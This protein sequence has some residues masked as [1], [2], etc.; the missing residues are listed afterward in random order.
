MEKAFSGR[1][2][3]QRSTFGGG[4]RRRP[5]SS[6]AQLVGDVFHHRRRYDYHIAYQN[7]IIDC[8][9]N[10]RSIAR[11]PAPAHNV[12]IVEDMGGGYPAHY[13]PFPSR[14]RPFFIM[15]AK[16]GRVRV[17]FFMGVNIFQDL[18]RMSLNSLQVEGPPPKKMKILFRAWKTSPLFSP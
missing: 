3:P 14:S 7:Q 2:A 4:Y 15:S 16:C 6:W 5:S 9:I 13:V 12:R 10:S 11:G 17:P 1:P 18:R 8:M